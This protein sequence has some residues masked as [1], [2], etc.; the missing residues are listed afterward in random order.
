MT[1]NF[2]KRFENKVLYDLDFADNIAL[3]TTIDDDAQ[4][5]T[6]NLS[7]CADQTGL[8]TSANKTLDTEN[9]YTVFNFGIHQ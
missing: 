7:N 4:I 1:V 5:K 3:T 9:T 8:K 2:W 6:V